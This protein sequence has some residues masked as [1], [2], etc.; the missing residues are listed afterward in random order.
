MC[1][2]VLK[3]VP[4][5]FRLSLRHEGHPRSHFPTSEGRFGQR[6]PLY[7]RSGIVCLN[8]HNLRIFLILSLSIFVG[9]VLS[10]TTSPKYVMTKAAYDETVSSLNGHVNFI[11]S[12]PDR[13]IG[14]T[15]LFFIHPPGTRVHGTV[16]FFHG[17]S[18]LA[19]GSR[20]RANFL[21]SRKF[22]SSL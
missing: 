13:R 16:I 5:K 8:M 20:V 6:F 17:Y 21:F 4:R 10:T 9:K 18:S 7:H 3:R 2:T 19:A 12:L 22:T 14:S 11:N 1:G 15:P